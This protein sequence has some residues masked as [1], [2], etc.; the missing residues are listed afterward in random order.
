MTKIDPANCWADDALG[1]RAQH[2]QVLERLLV[3]KGVAAADS[4]SA[5]VLNLDAPWGSGKSFFLKRF[6][7]QLRQK[8]VVVL[9]DAW[10]SDYASDP[11]MPVLTSVQKALKPLAGG[12]KPTMAFQDFAKTGARV[13]GV[14]A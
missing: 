5:F 8:H 7:A 14:F 12:A 6:A 3:Q 1:G 9:V 11:L 4:D 13:A 10:K 2:A